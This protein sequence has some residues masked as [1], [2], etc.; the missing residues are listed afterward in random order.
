[1]RKLDYDKCTNFKYNSFNL[2]VLLGGAL[3]F[4]SFDTNFCIKE[5]ATPAAGKHLHAYIGLP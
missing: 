4:K 1:M 5:F 3:T 2:D